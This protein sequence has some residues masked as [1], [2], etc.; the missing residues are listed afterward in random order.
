MS[1]EKR[2]GIKSLTLLALCSDKKCRQILIKEDTAEFLLKCIAEVEGAV[3]II[4]NP[5]EGVEIQDAVT[6]ESVTVQRIKS[7]KYKAKVF[8]KAEKI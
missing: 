8:G 1:K 2:P 4:S 5:V 3:R 7:S 6:T